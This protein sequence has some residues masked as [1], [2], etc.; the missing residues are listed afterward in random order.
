MPARLNAGE[1]IGVQTPKIPF[2][3]YCAIFFDHLGEH[4]SH[5]ERDE[6]H[7]PHLKRMALSVLLCRYEYASATQGK[8]S[9]PNQPLNCQF[10][11][12]IREPLCAPS[13]RSIGPRY[14]HPARSCH[15]QRS[16]AR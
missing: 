10:P 6:N 2:R 4:D 15:I 9:Q 7:S 14:R 13:V 16:L 5:N 3:S 11:I 12:H 1:L 8:P